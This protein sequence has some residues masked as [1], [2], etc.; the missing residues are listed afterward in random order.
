[1]I[2]AL[3]GAGCAP[4]APIHPD[5]GPQCLRKHRREMRERCVALKLHLLEISHLLAVPARAPQA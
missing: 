3:E 2:C 4:W 1:M 5:L